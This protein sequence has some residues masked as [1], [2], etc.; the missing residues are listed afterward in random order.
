[1]FGLQRQLLLTFLALRQGPI[2]NAALPAGATNALEIYE[3]Y[4]RG[5]SQRGKSHE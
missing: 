3:R 1:M 2:A 5:A 4:G